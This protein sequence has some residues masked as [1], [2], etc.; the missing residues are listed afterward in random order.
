MH[1]RYRSYRYDLKTRKKVTPTPA[2]KRLDFQNEGQHYMFAFRVAMSLGF[3]FAVRIA[4]AE[5][6]DGSVLT[7]AGWGAVASICLCL[8]LFLRIEK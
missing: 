5:A 6:A 3:L 4:A 1:R 8:A 7:A 2:R